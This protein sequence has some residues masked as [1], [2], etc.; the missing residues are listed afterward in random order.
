MLQGPG[1]LAADPRADWSDLLSADFFGTWDQPRG[2]TGYWRPLVLAS[3]RLEAWLAGG[4]LPGQMW[5]AHVVTIL[6]HALASVALWALL[7]RLG[8]TPAASL[9]GAALFA[10][11][12]AHVESVAWSS[13]R[14]ETLPAALAWAG[15]ALLLRRVVA[16]RPRSAG[17][18][19]LALAL[20]ALAPLAKESAVLLVALAAPLAWLGGRSRRASLGLPLGALGLALVARMACFGLAGEVDAEAYT[21]PAETST[22]WLTWLAVIP[23]LLRLAIWPGEATPIHPLAPV[24]SFGADVLV[25]GLVLGLGCTAGLSAWR[26]RSAPGV[27]CAGLLTGTLLLLAP[28]LR[29]PMGFEEVA[30]PL[31]ER[32]VYAL[33]AAVCLLAGQGLARV[34]GAHRL[35]LPAVLLLLVGGLAPVT[36]QRCTAWADD[37]AFARAALEQAP[38]SATFWNHLGVARL[39]ALR[40]GQAA[41]GDEA[42]QAFERALTLR[43][44]DKLPELNRFL[45]LAMLGRDAEAE[46]R[47]RD[48]ERRHGADPHVLANLAEWRLARGQLDEGLR[49]LK[50]ELDTGRARPGVASA[51]AQLEA[52]RAAR[53]ATPQP[54]PLEGG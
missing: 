5:L 43:P 34:A 27:F 52:E 33:S 10:L 51:V 40:S 6:C 18:D 13:G 29:I 16:P 50:A 42:L 30:G 28:W 47:A 9:L 44:G 15:T 12:P 31:Y 54:D 21:G 22:R 49:L 8:L 1:S 41:A 14:V 24:E 3:F 48:L 4:S 20:L 11:H 37:E 32:Y 25:G 39:E 7:R 45:T 2:Q 38:G 23:R 46:P 19:A 26:R 36:A 53:A 17:S 35:A